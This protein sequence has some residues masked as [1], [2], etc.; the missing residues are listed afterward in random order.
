MNANT[1]HM[2]ADTQG[3]VGPPVE[4]APQGFGLT[5]WPRGAHT[6]TDALNRA[7]VSRLLQRVEAQ[8]VVED[9]KRQTFRFKLVQVFSR[10]RFFEGSSEHGA[11][12]RRMLPE[13]KAAEQ[14]LCSWGD[15]TRM[16]QQPSLPTRWVTDRANE[17]GILA[18]DPKPPTFLSD[19]DAQIDRLVAHFPSTWQQTARA[20]WQ[21]LDEPRE[22]RADRARVSIDTLKRRCEVIRWAIKIA[23]EDGITPI[24]LD[25]APMAE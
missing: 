23:L 21:H 10:G 7:E 14:R 12:S 20:N 19:Q 18:G 6:I 25:G 8:P 3:Q 22:A 24:P 17:G 16:H 15:S 4:D 5:V 11:A 13:L 1:S 9:V 2:D